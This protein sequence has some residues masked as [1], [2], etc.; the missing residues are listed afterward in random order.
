MKFFFTFIFIIPLAY[1]QP[2]NIDPLIE[3]PLLSRRCKELIK[4]RDNKILIKQKLSSLIMRTEKLI[5]KAKKKQ[6]TG[7]SKLEYTKIKLNNQLR[8]TNIQ[9]KGMEEGIIRKGCPGITL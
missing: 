9:I 3:K 8:F 4:D 5:K 6:K 2:K 1:S 7:K